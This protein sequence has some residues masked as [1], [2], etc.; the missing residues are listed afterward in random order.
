M[1]LDFSSL[2][3]DAAAACMMTIREIAESDVTYFLAFPSYVTWTEPCVQLSFF[4]RIFEAIMRFH[5]SNSGNL[6]V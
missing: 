1:L 5:K 4:G 3:M 2:S 6:A